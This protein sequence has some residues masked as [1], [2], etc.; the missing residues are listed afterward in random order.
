M[1][2]EE[3]KENIFRCEYLFFSFHDNMSNNNH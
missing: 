3:V 2:L 1:E